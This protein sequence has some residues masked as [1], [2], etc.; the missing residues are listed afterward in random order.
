MGG[1]NTPPPPPPVSTSKGTDLNCLLGGILSLG[2]PAKASSP[3]MKELF[4]GV[5]RRGNSSTA[6]YMMYNDVYTTK[7]K[8]G[9]SRLCH[10]LKS[11]AQTS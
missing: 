5:W 9:I 10:Q 1:S 7:L 4:F 8:G 11:A 6:S 2:L 3:V